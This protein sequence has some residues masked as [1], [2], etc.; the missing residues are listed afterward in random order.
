VPFLLFVA[1]V[2]IKKKNKYAAFPD[3]PFLFT[4]RIIPTP[5]LIICAHHID[6]CNYP[7]CPTPLYRG[8]PK[9]PKTR[10]EGALS[11]KWSNRGKGE[12]TGS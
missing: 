6:L 4:F 9:G 2:L 5:L 3:M 7:G 8:P 11:E 12:V 1:I 10:G